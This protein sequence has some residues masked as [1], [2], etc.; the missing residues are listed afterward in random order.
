[1]AETIKIE[2][3]NLGVRYI[4]HE[5]VKKSGKMVT[6]KCAC[7]EVVIKELSAAR[8]APRCKTCSKNLKSSSQRKSNNDIKAL[9]EQCDCELVDVSGIGAK[10]KIKIKCICGKETERELRNLRMNGAKC[11][12]CNYAAQREARKIS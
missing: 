2:L 11:P 1:M 4:E 9:V 3:E 7:G 8:S 5:R 12:N 10:K 6:F